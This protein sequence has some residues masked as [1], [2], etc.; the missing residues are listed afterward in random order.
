M[1]RWRTLHEL[2]VTATAIAD[3]Q[4]AQRY[5]AHR[6]VTR[7]KRAVEYNRRAGELGH[8]VI[9]DAQL[10]EIKDERDQICQ[11]YAGN[12]ELD[13]GWADHL[14][15]GRPT[16]R[17]LEEQ[18]DHTYLRPYYQHASSPVHSDAHGVLL[19]VDNR[20]PR[21]LITGPAVQGL[22]DPL[23]LTA[24][25]VKSVTMQLLLSNK[26]AGVR[27]VLGVEVVDALYERLIETLGEIDDSPANTTLDHRDPSQPRTAHDRPLSAWPPLTSDDVKDVM[28]A[29]AMTA[30]SESDPLGP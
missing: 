24:L 7:Y 6:V 22:I 4:T 29:V 18:M 27:G 10:K 3:E 30:G 1:A 12:F 19:Q 13:Y 11:Q 21:A 2:A 17:A 28:R 5:L 14:V 9:S 20:D 26:N 23:Q 16:F 25:S 8:E 15:R